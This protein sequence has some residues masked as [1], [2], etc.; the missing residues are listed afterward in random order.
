M[1][2]LMVA[3]YIFQMGDDESIPEITSTLVPLVHCIFY[4]CYIS[5]SK[6]GIFH[7]MAK[8]QRFRG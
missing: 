6:E 2:S 3:H 7:L 4:L 1:T 8:C 5:C